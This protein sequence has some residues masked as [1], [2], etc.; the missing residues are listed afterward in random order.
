M[1][2]HDPVDMDEFVIARFDQFGFRVRERARP[3]VIVQFAIDEKF[4]ADGIPVR[5]PR[6][7]LPP[8]TMQ[9]RGTIIEHAL[10]HG[11]GALLPALHASSDDPSTHRGGFLEF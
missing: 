1:D 5:H 11:P 6:L 7:R 9:P 2:G 3:F 4:A 8:T 10:E